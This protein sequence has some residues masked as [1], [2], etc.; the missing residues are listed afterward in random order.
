MSGVGIFIVRDTGNEDRLN[1]ESKGA[2]D[3]MGK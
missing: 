2:D 3:W 1:R